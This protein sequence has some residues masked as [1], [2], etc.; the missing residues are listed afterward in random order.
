MGLSYEEVKNIN[1]KIIYASISGFGEKGPYSNQR[2][3]DPV[4]QALSGLQ[5]YKEIKKQIFQKW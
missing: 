3:Y 4:I 5:I 2:V 1:K